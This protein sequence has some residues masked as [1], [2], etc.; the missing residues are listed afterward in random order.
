ASRSEGAG[1][2]GVGRTASHSFHRFVVRWRMHGIP[3]F[4]LAA[5][6]AT[7][8]LAASDVLAQTGSITGSVID[9]DTR[10]PLANVQVHLPSLGRG[11]VTAANGRF[12]ITDVPVGTYE[13]EAQLLG[14]G[15]GRQTVEVRAGEAAV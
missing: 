11:M 3:R 5:V 6:A 12:L 14:Y 15:T 13:V 10:Q 9:R 8:A 1:G 2:R 4:T 7:L